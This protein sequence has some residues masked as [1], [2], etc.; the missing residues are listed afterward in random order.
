MDSKVK[1]YLKVLEEIGSEIEKISE[2]FGKVSSEIINKETEKTLK[3]V[4]DMKL[5]YKVLAN[6]FN[7]QYEKLKS[8]TPPSI[9]KESHDKLLDRYGNYVNS[10]QLSIDSLNENT[11]DVD[12][13]TFAT[14]VGD[15][16]RASDEIVAISNEMVDTVVSYLNGK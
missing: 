8:L 10:T 5:K 13:G 11:G 14:G 4:R 16:G 9:L 1:E 3:D 2:N 12:F 15:Q 6:D 7:R